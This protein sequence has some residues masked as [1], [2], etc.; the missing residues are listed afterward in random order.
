MRIGLA[1]AEFHHPVCQEFT[2]ALEQAASSCATRPA[3][4]T[5]LT[6][7]PITLSDSR[8]LPPIQS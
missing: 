6:R 7:M 1:V 8:P 2:D 5:K 4:E 3:A